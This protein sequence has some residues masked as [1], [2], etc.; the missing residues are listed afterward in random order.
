MCV[1]VYVHVCLCAFMFA[2]AR[3]CECRCVHV[4]A[5][6]CGA[7]V[8]VCVCVV[9]QG[10]GI[11]I[12]EGDQAVRVHKISWRNCRWDTL[13]DV[14]VRPHSQQ[15]SRASAPGCTP[16]HSMCH[17]QDDCTPLYLTNLPVPLQNPSTTHA[18]ARPR[19]VRAHVPAPRMHR[20]RP[21]LV[22]MHAHLSSSCAHQSCTPARL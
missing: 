18:C 15:A 1:R 4:S 19:H 12:G 20:V 6:M 17:M 13:H 5:S 14:P 11:G 8:S 7:C 21:A 2:C 16:L 3:V 9:L 10:L 22:A